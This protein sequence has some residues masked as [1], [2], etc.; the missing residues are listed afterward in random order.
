MIVAVYPGSFDPITNGH[1]DI[2]ERASALFAKL[3]VAV[4]DKPDKP[5]LFS[6]EERVEMI[7]EAI[8]DLPNVYI[9]PYSGLTIDFIHKVGG[10]AMIRGLRMISDFEKEFEMA[11]MSKRLAPDVDLICLM[12][13]CRYQFISS[14]LIKEVAK[15][16]GCLD[17]MVPEHVAIALKEKFSAGLAKPRHGK[18]N[19]K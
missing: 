4:Y 19:I 9:E 6:V 3:I 10:K 17:G 16:G 7:K 15:L 11:A 12:T 13:D 1:F 2:I 14:S 5:L 18:P 8:R